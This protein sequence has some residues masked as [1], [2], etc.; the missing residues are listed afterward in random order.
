MGDGEK[1]EE[2]SYVS[3]IS[4]MWWKQMESRRERER[5]SITF[6]GWENLYVMW[7]I[8]KE[9]KREREKE[10]KFVVSVL[11]CCCQREES[12]GCWLDCITIS[13][14]PNV[15]LDFFQSSY[16]TC[17]DWAPRK[18]SGKERNNRTIGKNDRNMS[19]IN[20]R[21]K[22]VLSMR[23]RNCVGRNWI[24]EERKHCTGK[25]RES[26]KLQEARKS[27]SLERVWT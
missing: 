22:I 20:M 14:S 11:M 5:E 3:N 4:K 24:G 19:V 23:G 9:R 12:F 15:I 27:V 25:E 16:L 6:H 10:E 8:E 26:K 2:K 7:F 21:G 18:T 13:S 1:D 17:I